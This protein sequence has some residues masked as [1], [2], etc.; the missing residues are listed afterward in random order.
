MVVIPTCGR[1]G[2]LSRCLDGVRRQSHAAF[3]VLVVDN[4]SRGDAIR[5]VARRWGARYVAEPIVGL[6][7]ARN[8][9]ARESDKEIVVYLDDDAVPQGDWLEALVREFHDPRVMAVTGRVVPLTETQSSPGPRAVFGTCLRK[10]RLV[11][12]RDNPHWFEWVNF[13]G[14][15]IGAN[16]AIRR[17]AFAVWPGFDVRLGRGAGISGGEENYAFFALLDRGGRLVYTPDATVAHRTAETFEELYA[18][19]LHGVATVSAYALL[20]F[21]EQ[22]RYR[23]R[24]LHYVLNGIRGSARPWC[25]EQALAAPAPILAP[26]WRQTMAWLSGPWLYARSRFA[27]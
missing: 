14:I 23:V 8:R 9:G 19:H 25:E 24:L 6:S 20:L 16:M 26:R 10:T 5:E 17:S 12:D 15:G 13:G 27:A 2:Y 7:R 11:L 18:A 4:G 21:A 22:P 1:P 3:D